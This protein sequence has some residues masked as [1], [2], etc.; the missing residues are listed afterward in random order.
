[1]AAKG[2]S[3]TSR[4]RCEEGEGKSEKEELGRS[5]SHWIGSVCGFGP[6]ARER[7]DNMHTR[8][9][10]SHKGNRY[11]LAVKGP[12]GVAFVREDVIVQR[13]GKREPRLD[14]LTK[15]SRPGKEALDREEA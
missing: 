8:L 9:I 11:R 14:D 10:H 2:G 1:L 15:V 3:L 5:S 12:T 4:S 7:N 6:L 13:R